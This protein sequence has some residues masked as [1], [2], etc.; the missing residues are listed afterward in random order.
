MASAKKNFYLSALSRMISVAASIL[1]VPFLLE[2]LG[3]EEY[4]LW[5]TLTSIVGFIGLLNFGFGNSIRNTV[6]KM[7]ITNEEEVRNEFIGYFKLLFKVAIVCVL[8]TLI[9]IAQLEIN[10]GLR[11]SIIFLYIPILLS[12]P[13]LFGGGVLQG[14]FKS[15]IHAIIQ[16]SVGWIFLIFV[17]FV[18]K[19][20]GSVNAYHLALVWGGLFWLTSAVIFKKALDVVGLK[21]SN[22]GK[23]LKGNKKN[24]RW[25]IGF[26]FLLLQMSSIFLYGIGNLLIYNN[27]GANQAASY[28]TINKLFQAIL[29]FYSIV[30]GVMWSEI[31]KLI[32]YGDG[33]ELRKIFYK[34]IALASMFAIFAFMLGVFGPTIVG[35]WTSGKIE[36][37]S[38]ESLAMAF[39]VSVQAFA[40][41][42]AVFM[43]AFE[44]LNIQILFSAVMMI[45]IIPLC[46]VGFK[47]NYGIATVPIVSG[48]LTFLAMV[49]FNC[50][51][52]LLI[53]AV[54]SG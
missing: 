7:Q 10:E 2:V 37:Q 11:A 18:Y 16:G 41:V 3:N 15:G 22:L 50:Y 1:I 30:I 4:G 38:H 26:S 53:K 54:K 21:I 25:K 14:A 9:F 51:S 19:L 42:G 39:L 33:V 32:A 35:K 47:L 34:L 27:L 48:F 49:C 36:I 8:I 5:V 45:M 46:I 6:S 12:I 20:Q 28:D 29:S 23:L 17:L 44:K 13:L 24:K 43:N 52:Y 40:Y 31:A